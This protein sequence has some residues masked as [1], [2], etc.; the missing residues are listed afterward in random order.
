MITS[1]FEYKVLDESGN[2]LGFKLVDVT[3]NKMVY[4]NTTKTKAIDRPKDS[5]YLQQLV[6]TVGKKKDKTNIYS[7]DVLYMHWQYH[8]DYPITQIIGFHDRIKAFRLYSANGVKNISIGNLGNLRG[9][10][11]DRISNVLVSSLHLA[12]KH[13]GFDMDN[14]IIKEVN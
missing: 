2:H 10:I 1:V 3:K 14:Y 8:P 6:T 13:D 11:I 4:L 12:L 5:A 7:G 9:L